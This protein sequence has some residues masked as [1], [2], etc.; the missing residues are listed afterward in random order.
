VKLLFMKNANRF[1]TKKLMI[2]LAALI[3][4][5][6]I[7]TE[8]ISIHHSAF[9]SNSSQILNRT[10]SI[11]VP[12]KLQMTL[13]NTEP[14]VELLWDD[15][16]DYGQYSG[17]EN[18]GY[19]VTESSNGVFRISGVH[20]YNHG[21][22]DYYDWTFASYDSEGTRLG[23]NGDGSN[24]YDQAY[25]VI[26]CRNGDWVIA[27]HMWHDFTIQRR[28][29]AGGLIWQNRIYY[30]VNIARSV[31]ECSNG[32]IAACGQVSGIGAGGSDFYLLRTD[33]SG[34]TLWN[35]TYGGSNDDICW[36]MKECSNGDFILS[37]ST[38][39]FGASGYD[40]MLVRTA[41]DG[42][43]LWNYT[44]GGSANDELLG[45][46]ECDDGGFV[47][48]GYTRSYGG[49]GSDMWLLKTD[50]TG[51]YLW[52]R[53][54][55]LAPDDTGNSLVIAW[56]GGFTLL[57]NTKS[58][59]LGATD[60]WLVHTNST[61]HSEWNTTYG[62][63]SNGDW[64]QGSC[65]LTRSRA[66]GY[67]IAAST[68]DV[69]DSTHDLWILRIL[70]PTEPIVIVGDD[71][72]EAQD[73][74]GSG[75]DLD[76]Y[77]IEDWVIDRKE[78]SG[79]CIEIQNTTAHFRIENCTLTNA[80]TLDAAGIYLYN[81]TNAVI[82][83]NTCSN[84][85]HGIYAELTNVTI[86]EDNICETNSNNGINLLNSKFNTIANN[87]CN[88]NV[89]ENGILIEG[90][91]HNNTLWNNTCVGN[92]HSG[93]LIKSSSNNTIANNTMINN[94]WHGVY[95]E[96]S[97][98]NTVA[99]NTCYDNVADGIS[100]ITWS[101]NN[102]L[103]TNNCS[104]NDRYGIGFDSNCHY[105]DLMNNTCRYN[106]E[107]GI[108]MY[109][110]NYNTVIDNNCNNNIQCGIW[111]DQL[112]DN[113]M[114][115][116]NLCSYSTSSSGI[117]LNT[118]NSNNHL[119]NNTCE[120]NNEDGIQALWVSEW[121]TVVNNTCSQNG[122]NGILLYQADYNTI[123]DNI[124]NDNTIY[125]IYVNE[126]D[127]S[128][129]EN[130][131]C[132]FNVDGIRIDTSEF[133]EI[134]NNTCTQSDYAGVHLYTS[135]SS[136]IYHNTLNDNTAYGIYVNDSD[137]CTLE[138]NTCHFNNDGIRIDTS[139]FS[140]IIN[141][142]CTQSDYAGIYLYKSN[143]NNITRNT[144]NDNTWYGIYLN[145]S[146]LNN[147]TNNICQNH[148][149]GAGIYLNQ[150]DNN[151]LTNNTCNSNQVGIHL[152]NSD[153][154]IITNNT[155]IDNIH[156]GIYFDSN[157]DANTV[158]WNN[159]ED[160]TYNIWNE[161]VSN[162]FDYNYY[163]DY[164]GPDNDGDGIGDIPYMHD[165]PANSEDTYPLMFPKGY[166]YLTWTESISDHWIEFPESW[167]YNLNVIVETSVH[168][169]WVNDTVRFSVDS[170]GLITNSTVLLAG[171]YHVMV[172]VNDTEGHVLRGAFTLTVDDAEPP[173]WTETPV[174]YY[175]NGKQPVR[176]DLN[177][178][179]ISGI[180]TWW[181]NDTIRFSINNDGVIINIT[182][183]MIGNWGIQVWVN[184]SLNHV[185]TA[186]FSVVVTSAPPDWVITPTDKVIEFYAMFSYDLDATDPAGVDCWW[187]NDTI[188]FNVDINGII[189]NKT[190]LMTG[191]YG[192][193]IFVNNSI[194]S[195]KN[196]TFKVTVQDTTDPVWVEVPAN[197]VREY[198]ITFLY[199]LDVSD[200]SSLDTWW[201]N[202][203][204]HFSITSDG[205][206]TSI[207]DL[208]VLQYGLQVFVND[209]H[210]NVLSGSFSLAVVQDPPT[211][212]EIP[213]D[214]MVEFGEDF[215]YPLIATAPL[216]LVSWWL[217]DTTYFTIDSFGVITNTTPLAVGSYAV[218]VSV[219]DI[220]EQVLSMSIA[221]E[222]AD[223]IAPSLTLVEDQILEDGVTI[224]IQLS[225]SDLSGVLYWE[226]NDTERF[227]ITSVGYLFNITNL[228]VGTYS[229]TI[230]VFDVYYNSAS[231]TIQVIIFEASSPT[232][233]G[234]PVD[235]TLEFGDSFSYDLDALDESGI[236]RWGISDTVTFFI[237]EH[238]H[239]T[240]ATLLSVGVYTIEVWVSD[241][242]GHVLSSSFTV[243]V[244]DTIAPIWT[245]PPLNQV[246]PF[247]DP[248]EVSL[249]ATDLSG[250]DRFTVNDTKRFRIT[251][252]NNLINIISLDSGVY[253]LNI[254][255]YDQFENSR[256]TV[257]TITVAY[258]GYTSD[259]ILPM[260][261]IIGGGGL[262]AL[263]IIVVVL[264]IVRS[265]T[266]PS[267]GG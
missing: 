54:Y 165:G 205:T 175:V 94:A 112:S 155:C 246:L 69:S 263:I 38:L 198:G 266:S 108:Y 189:T 62:R 203:T 53:T 83:N 46:V 132:H 50:S 61:G 222:V 12:I 110:S 163:S 199:D 161:Q 154:N 265:R 147:L 146:N 7:P 264:R 185:Q 164:D 29:S 6:I 74:P 48:T 153:S 135:N 2:S 181:I 91:S 67:A 261:L 106:D 71:D 123:T 202:D 194:G 206:I 18:R 213:E 113:N 96:G 5:L 40:G 180:H 250:V 115:I 127:H 26:A 210:G 76:P 251:A 89:N 1:R 64:V 249:E 34:N 234:A 256:S 16:Y 238:G 233:V 118:I 191:I 139:E 160:S 25:S 136:N 187:T 212:L 65:G 142:T 117:V 223:T 63:S 100:L 144:L 9:D 192:L 21:S 219:N 236:D 103:I 193:Q 84:N 216:G 39:S 195:T 14:P 47:A 200:Y 242:V 254:T 60:V 10:D 36:S 51:N 114:I 148:I 172:Y 188:N 68:Y 207:V 75:T 88:L 28:N 197:Q 32:D 230:T 137:H 201:L 30:S 85:Y 208:P 122:R 59:G 4:L 45:V 95:M 214:Q 42:T 72:F 57:G 267:K 162:L 111:I 190:I 226:V 99:N 35:T 152:E 102:T 87:T 116:D 179:D 227:A 31:V 52:N 82:T 13:S 159:L 20:E 49:G 240:N 130:N 243:E 121:N 258:G 78:S 204:V 93:L 134:I 86:V 3:F 58:Y 37:G 248:L 228:D 239:I 157:A 141:N 126:S 149:L 129:L 255:V 257:I 260:L 168:L 235:Q 11:S 151:V 97:S 182:V 253:V 66:R 145:E 79:H 166:L 247:G 124:C 220:W 186:I 27:G 259:S 101:T 80:T 119:T 23:I 17:E 92:N 211:W 120:H 241:T 178:T 262:G 105:N 183:L 229:L 138:N 143:S 231:G 225:A 177:A 209:T 133:S 90:T 22:G 131:T 73:W 174:D 98:F 33:S 245:N 224:S 169:W 173:I 70:D 167:Q 171:I 104:F 215:R 8:P 244:E 41:S 19:A 176:Y 109:L 232:W 107:H 156:S 56:D 81:V 196:A 252:A 15:V 158:E 128:A 77:V 237:D 218:Q 125:G 150:S 43:R 170:N 140:E 221:I 217:N 184:D 55:G 44:Y 24:D